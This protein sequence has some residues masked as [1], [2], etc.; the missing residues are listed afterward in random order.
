M[1][2]AGLIGADGTIGQAYRAKIDALLAAAWRHGIRAILCFEFDA[3]RLAET[4]SA[5][6]WRRSMA[7]IAHAYRDDGRILMW[8]LKNEPDDDAKWTPGTRA[9]LRD[10]PA[11]LR[12]C[13]TNHPTTI[14]ITWRMDRL[15]E[16]GL[17]DVLQY[18]EYAPKTAL[19]ADG[20]PRVL[21]SIANQRA[22]NGARPLLIG[23]FGMCT[24]RDPLHGA[25]PSL[26]AKLGDAAGTEADQDR[27]YGIVLAAAEEARV[28]GVLAWCLHDYP[29]RNPS[30]SHFGLVRAD[31]SLKPAAVRLRETYARWRLPAP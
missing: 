8:D 4:N 27:L 31:D 26:L 12:A 5:A 23:E 28:A 30:E 22:A 11:V 25:D 3:S 16:V 24:A 10:A 21:K 19:F 2:E 14:G 18:H 9:Y 6:R 20:A 7:G 13:D 1:E 17:P 15:R 29:I